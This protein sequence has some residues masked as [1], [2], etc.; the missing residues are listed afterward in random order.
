MWV[1]VRLNFNENYFT[2]QILNNLCRLNDS[3]FSSLIMQNSP[4]QHKLQIA[5]SK[6]KS[7][8]KA[9]QFPRSHR[10]LSLMIFIIA[11]YGMMNSSQAMKYFNKTSVKYE[12]GNKWNCIRCMCGL[13]TMM[14]LMALMMKEKRFPCAFIWLNNW[15]VM[16]NVSQFL[17][18]RSDFSHSRCH[19]HRINI[20]NTRKIF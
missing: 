19:Y 9:A 11:R 4:V 2:A 20:Y 10:K 6:C 18:T 8:K 7:R 13:S 12:I 1:I 17:A 14:A 3:Q 5:T 15:V 16:W